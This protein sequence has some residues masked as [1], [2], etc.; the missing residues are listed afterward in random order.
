M[1]K[2]HFFRDFIGVLNSNIFSIICGVLVVILLTRILGPEGFGLYYTLLV[3][4]LLVV[5]MTHLGIRGASIF[6]IG[7]KKYND[8]DIVSSVITILIFT[9]LL[10]VISSIV[11]YY[12]F[13]KG[14]K[15]L[16]LQK[17]NMFGFLND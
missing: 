2:R 9:S 4:P 17:L 1:A 11:A 6:M 7:Q 13:Y 16:Y 12:F 5:G 14:R 10:G 15:F 8:N 3:I